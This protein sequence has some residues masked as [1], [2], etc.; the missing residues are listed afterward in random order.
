MTMDAAL[1]EH[2][3]L[4]LP[5]RERAWLADRLLTSLDEANQ[6]ARSDAWGAESEARL[7]AYLAGDMTALDGP[8]ALKALRES[9][10]R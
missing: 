3:A 6:Q 1:L 9:L 8:A 4:H 2:E 7:D 10:P 5:T